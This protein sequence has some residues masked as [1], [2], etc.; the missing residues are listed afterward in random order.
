MG[1][2]ENY[3]WGLAHTLQKFQTPST[4]LHTNSK[5]DKYFEN[6]YRKHFLVKYFDCSLKLGGM[7]GW[8]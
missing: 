1:K 4:K 3:T 5:Y 2:T 6:G 7:V 8:D